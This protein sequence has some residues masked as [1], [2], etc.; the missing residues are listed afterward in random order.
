MAAM[1][2]GSGLGIWSR[3]SLCINCVLN[4]PN[5]SSPPRSLRHQPI[6]RDV[7]DALEGIRAR[8]GC[9]EE[10]SKHRALDTDRKRGSYGCGENAGSAMARRECVTREQRWN[11]K[12]GDGKGGHCSC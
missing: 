2:S 12:N 5:H 9:G 3:P 10:E 4:L 6:F 11:G 7:I 8:L 1:G